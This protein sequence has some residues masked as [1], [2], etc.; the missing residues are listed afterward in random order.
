[1]KNQ[2]LKPVIRKFILGTGLRGWFVV[3]YHVHPTGKKG[4]EITINFT[5][6]Q[7]NGNAVYDVGFYVI[8]EDSFVRWF[9]EL[10]AQQSTATIYAPREALHKILRTIKH[11]VR[12]Q[13]HE[14]QILFLIFSNTHSVVTRKEVTL[15][16]ID[17]ANKIKS[18]IAKIPAEFIRMMWE[19]GEFERR[20]SLWDIQNLAKSKGYTLTKRAI[21]LALK[22]ADFITC[23]GRLSNKVPVYSQVYPPASSDGTMRLP[24]HI[25]IFDSLA[26]HPEIKSASSSLFKDGHYTQA[27]TEALKKVNNMVKRKSGMNDL[28]GKKLMLHVFSPNSPV[29]KLNQLGTNSE[30]D[31][32][33]GFMH[34]FAGSIQGIRNPKIHDDIVQDDDPFKTIEYLCLASLLAKTIDTAI[35]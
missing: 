4:D 19:S 30:T 7:G 29:L 8:N 1:M 25:E 18:D 21:F 17:K 31:E 14:D 3:P 16:I 6:A 13:I 12:L 9:S 22:Q 11:S 32:Q 35:Q 2:T 5:V 26:L 33:E 15:E 27:I 10:P 28:D 20:V 34:L 23:V 24:K